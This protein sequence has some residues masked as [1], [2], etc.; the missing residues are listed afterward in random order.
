MNGQEPVQPETLLAVSTGMNGLGAAATGWCL[1]GG[2]D[3]FVGFRFM[4]FVLV[5]LVT[6]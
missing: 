2:F 3:D 5:E 1:V 6:D 4:M